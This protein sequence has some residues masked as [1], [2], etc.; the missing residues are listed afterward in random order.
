M[1]PVIITQSDQTEESSLRIWKRSCMTRFLITV[2]R[3]IFELKNFLRNIFVL[4]IFRSYDGL[5]KYFN[6]IFFKHVAEE[7]RVC[8]IRGYHVWGGSCWR[9]TGV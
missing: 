7:K 3:E 1:I 9:S 4:K 6:A 8:C 2:N 5:R